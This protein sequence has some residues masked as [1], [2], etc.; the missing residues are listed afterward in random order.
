MTKEISLQELDS[1]AVQ[2][3]EIDKSMA[4]VLMDMGVPRDIA[5]TIDE[6]TD[7][8]IIIGNKLYDIGKILLLKIIEFIKA[9]PNLSAGIGLGIC[10]A[11]FNSVLVGIVPFI[12]VWLAPLV[13]KLTALLSIPLGAIVGALLDKKG[14]NTPQNIEEMLKMPKGS[15]VSGAIEALKKLCQ[16]FADIFQTLKS[17]IKEVK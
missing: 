9:N 12:G 10:I 4:R 1:L 6:L 8:A 13:A 14:E 17:E 11:A 7:K 2:V 15:I 16:L 3:K 5:Y